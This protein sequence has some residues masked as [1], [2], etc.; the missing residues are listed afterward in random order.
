[1]TAEEFC[2]SLHLELLPISED[3]L[4]KSKKDK[5]RTSTGPKTLK[6]DR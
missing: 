4:D 6:R 2:S 3:L 1:M 5:N